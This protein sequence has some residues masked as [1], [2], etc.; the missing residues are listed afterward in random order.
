MERRKATSERKTTPLPESFA[1]RFEMVVLYRLDDGTC[2]AYT[3]NN[4]PSNNTTFPRGR[5]SSARRGG[6]EGLET[7]SKAAANTIR[8]A[9]RENIGMFIGVGKK[10]LKQ[11]VLKYFRMKIGI[12]DVK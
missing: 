10:F 3:N 11:S 5:G 6:G 8:R 1:G 4:T 12:R 9:I 2:A 7:P